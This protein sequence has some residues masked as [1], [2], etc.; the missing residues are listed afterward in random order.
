MVVG[1]WTDQPH[2][3]RTL[4]RITQAACLS[5]SAC[6]LEEPPD[7]ELSGHRAI[8]RQGPLTR[9][10]FDIDSPPVVT[11]LRSGDNIELVSTLGESMDL[12]EALRSEQAPPSPQP[13]TIRIK[14]SGGAQLWSAKILWWQ[15]PREE[16][17]HEG[18]VWS[19]IF[20]G[21][22]KAR[23]HRKNSEFQSAQ[24]LWADSGETAVQVGAIAFALR[25]YAAAAYSA[26][27]NH[28][29]AGADGLLHRTD[30]I[31]ESAAPEL[32]KALLS[33]GWAVLHRRSNN[34]RSS[35]RR[36]L[37]VQ[38][39]LERQDSLVSLADVEMELRLLTSEAG[40]YRAA[41]EGSDLQVD[42]GFDSA[43]M[44]GSIL[45]MKL[46]A[47]Q[48]D[49]ISWD[50]N[51][52]R[53]MASQQ[54]A[55]FE[56][57][58]HPAEAGEAFMN[59]AYAESLV[60]EYEAA[61]GSWQKAIALDPQLETQP[62]GA[63]LRGRLAEQGRSW[64][65]AGSA[66]REVVD[67]GLE[68]QNPDYVWQAH[69]GLARVA[70]AQDERA[71]A[72]L[73]YEAALRIRRD[74]MLG[75]PLRFGRSTFAADRAEVVA[76]AVALFLSQGDEDA[77]FRVLDEESGRTLRDL[78]SRLRV[79]RLEGQARTTY[80]ERLGRYRRLKEDYAELR[81]A[82]PEGMKAVAAALQRQKALRAEMDEA[83][84]AAYEALEA[85]GTTQVEGV[86][87]K[88]LQD[89]LQEDEALLL[90][91]ELKGRAFRFAVTSTTAAYQQAAPEDPISSSVAA[92]L[93]GRRHVY[94]VGPWPKDLSLSP[95]TSRSDLPFA[96]LL[97]RTPLAPR[98]EALVLSNPSGDLP[99]ASQEGAWVSQRLKAR[100]LD[101]AEADM[102]RVLAG[103]ESARHLHFTGHG[104]GSAA[105]A[106][107]AHLVLADEQQLSLEDLVALRPKVG[108]VVLSG[109]ET[110]KGT[111][112]SQQ[113]KMSLADAFLISGA[114]WVLASDALVPDKETQAFVQAFYESGGLDDPAKT[115]RTLQAQS[116]GPLQAVAQ[117]FR[118]HGHRR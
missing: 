38:Q 48:A 74:T 12:L 81:R 101:G 28:D 73:A 80:L 113:E 60:G 61:L 34:L 59:L 79:S 93:R 9:Q 23:T 103:L 32:D 10:L 78:E 112:L 63:L 18:D 43:L 14:D 82:E 77:A 95:D 85:G 57:L 58:G 53:V 24:Q 83:F 91:A 29:L 26:I 17:F 68:D 16:A 106:W 51:E 15:G 31:L 107:S 39:L 50:L 21:F 110:G 97:T 52:L 72:R 96:S 30:K 89:V 86:S 102:T 47:M 8:I 5:L 111:Q 84:E 69:H 40:S 104:V 64:V 33:F 109:C 92:L 25:C 62:F 37:Q 44:Q 100:R 36:L 46:R 35:R 66:Y 11:G 27:R 4:C 19:R 55:S 6:T 1:G 94:G 65:E 75:A 116:E 70:E 3:L 99:F 49:A 13:W 115:L 42:S 108:T 76:D 87:R 71:A 2:V 98:G 41:I 117:A 20:L 105:D 67:R 45:W 54:V 56:Q 7:F 90:V 22:E 114:K 88:E 118:L